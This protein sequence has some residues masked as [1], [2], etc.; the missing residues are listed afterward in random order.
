[1]SVLWQDIRYGVRKLRKSP[2]FTAI[3]L[4]TLAIGIG[5]NTIMFSFSDAVMLQ[6][7]RHVKNPE[8][9]A[10]CTIRPASSGPVGYSEYLSVRDSGLAFSDLMVQSYGVEGGATLV[11]GDSAS[12]VQTLYVSLNYFSFL[13]VAPVLG[14]SFLPEEERLGG[15]S[16][17]VLSH[18]LWQRLGGNPKL[19]GEFLTINGIPCQ[20]VGVAPKDFTGVSFVGPDLWL[21]LG[22]YSAVSTWFRGLPPRADARG[23]RGYPVGLDIIGRLKPGV[24]MRVAQAQLQSLIPRFRAEDPKRWLDGASFSLRPPGRDIAHIEDNEVGRRRSAVFCLALMAVSTIILVIACLNLANMLIVQG[25]S[26][27]REIAVRLALGGGRWRIIRQLLAESGLLALLGGVLGVLLAVCGMRILNAWFA[28][29]TDVVTRVLQVGLNVRVLT[30]T[31][32]FCLI[33]TLLFGLRP[34]LRLSRRD[35]AGEMKASGGSVRGSVRRR[36]G[37]LSVAGQIALAVA[38]VFSASLLARSAVQTARPDPRFPLDEK[39]V[40]QIDPESARYDKVRSIQACAALADH[41]ASL[42]EV[43]ALGTSPHLFYGGGGWLSIRECRPGA[44][45]DGPRGPRARYG[46]RISAGRDYFAALGIPLLQGRLF[47]PLDSAPNAEKVAI[48][49]ES[50]ARHLRPD[51]NALGCFI[52]WGV[53]EFGEWIP[54]AYRVV[55]IVASMAGVREREPRPQMYMPTGA[56]QLSPYFYLHVADR[57]A[58]ELLRARMAEE[59]RR[60]DP[61]IPI[62]SVKTLAEIRNDNTDVWTARFLARLALAAAGA[63]L[64]LAALGIYAIKG[65]VVASRTSEIGIRKAMGATHG[66]IL[67]MVLREGLVLT[68]VAL[69]VGLLLGLAI[70]QV[71]ASLLYGIS[72][73]DPASIAATIA[74]LGAASLLAGYFPARRAA[75]VDPMVA[76]RYE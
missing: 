39:L 72:P 71:A 44:Q 33:A 16:V 76:L 17:V 73:A 20:V 9:L 5:A 24:N 15:A 40:V 34:A 48:I 32:G 21:P 13:G 11:R 64:F 36:R 55:G 43:K 59:I 25:A 12:R 65:Y 58:V 52:Q 75:K 60:V 3:A 53:V 37:G 31:L 46:T 67:G 38:L 45:E 50:L 51:G 63:A 8:Q 23:D 27:H 69:L 29:A 4:I 7:P 18:R 41:L 56:D 19:V 42:P 22:S 6:Q 1:M 61:H 70:A 49:D 35:I 62:L 54:D 66:N 57:R 10:Y 30:A 26:R 74:L 28:T 2:G 47:D 68:V 14:R